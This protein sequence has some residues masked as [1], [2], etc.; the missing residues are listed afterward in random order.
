MKTNNSLTNLFA[1]A[2]CRVHKKATRREVKA[3]YAALK[4]DPTRAAD[5]QL[6]VDRRQ[7]SKDSK[8]ATKVRTDTT[9]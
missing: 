9:D 8:K 6:Y 5:H 7:A 4:G 1:A 2:Y 3:A